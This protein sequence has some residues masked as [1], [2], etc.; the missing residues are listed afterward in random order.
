MSAQWSLKQTNQNISYFSYIVFLKLQCAQFIQVGCHNHSLCIIY[1]AKWITICLQLLCYSM[2]IVLLKPL[3]HWTKNP[4]TPGFCLQ[5]KRAQLAL[6][7]SQMTQCCDEC[8]VCWS[9]NSFRSAPNGAEFGRETTLNMI[10]K[11]NTGRQTPLLA[12]GKERIALCQKVYRHLKIW[13][14]HTYFL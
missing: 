9:V 10:H 13:H 14:K 2:D 4:P 1:A 5:W 8:C 12:I 3:S 7:P 11:K 6:I